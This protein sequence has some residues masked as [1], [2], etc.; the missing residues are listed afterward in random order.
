MR[1]QR[2][3]RWLPGFALLA[4]LCADY[5]SLRDGLNPFDPAIILALRVHDDPAQA[6]GPAWLAESARDLTGL[7][8]NDVAALVVFTAC[9]G[10]MLARLRRQAALLLVATT[11]ALALNAVLKIAVHRTRPDLVPDAPRVF[12][13]SFPSSHSMVSAAMLFALAAIVASVAHSPALRVF[14]FVMA[15]VGT[16]LV[17]LSRIYLG[18]H[19]PTDVLGGWAGG[20]FCAWAA[21]TLIGRPGTRD[22][23][24]E[25]GADKP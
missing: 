10:L 3:H 11:S 22:T 2:L 9:T 4:L 19:W 12:T 16:V 5:L 25:T 23:M 18:V 17:G 15:G 21:V 14:A 13:T 24:D 20:L 7:G 6:L 1:R 8:S